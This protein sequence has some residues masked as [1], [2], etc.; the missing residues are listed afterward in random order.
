MLQALSDG[1]LVGFAL[2]F[3]V[4]PVFFLLLDISINKGFMQAV[5][6]ATGVALS[7]ACC[8]ALAQLGLAPFAKNEWFIHSFGLAGGIT[9]IIIGVLSMMRKP[10]IEKGG[11][12]NNLVPDKLSAL[13]LKGFILNTLNPF[14]IIF[15]LG[16]STTI[17]TTQFTKPEI[18]SF[19]STALLTVLLTDTLKAFIA[20][21]LQRIVTENIL[22]WMNRISGIALFVYGI[23]IIY[24]SFFAHAI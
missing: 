5:A 11:L 18:F 17:T 2:A 10:S 4:G 3:L 14:A 21:K 9:L 8:A 20:E 1:F 22:L 16:V 7:D 13:A 24:K 6:F 23:Q 15:W 19:Y 12:G